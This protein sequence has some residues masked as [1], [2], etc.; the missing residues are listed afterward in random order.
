MAKQEDIYA[1]K[2]LLYAVLPVVKVI[3]ESRENFAKS[4][5][6]KSGVVQFSALDE[7]VK[8]GM[9]FVIENGAFIVKLETA[10]QPDLE[11]EFPNI[12]HFNRF[13]TGKTKKL[14]K[15]RGIRHVGLLVAVL[16]VLLFMPGLLLTSK[17]HEKQADKELYVK[18]MFYIATS[19]ISQLNHAGHPDVAAWTKYSPDRIIQ[20][21]VKDRP[22]YAAYLRVKLGKTKAARGRYERSKPFLTMLFD[23]IDSAMRIVMGVEDMISATEQG[24]VV[25][26]GPPEIGV[27]VGG[28]M[29]LV[30]AYTK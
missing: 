29:F 25:L 17:P 9:H 30:A 11:F 5:A 23:S 2:I 6:G 15:I 7:G 21:E 22:E 13:F 24:H 4:F 16:R 27:E 20:M 28:L 18:L 8:Y 3:V 26:L 14:P 19:G 12:A 1:N 10:E